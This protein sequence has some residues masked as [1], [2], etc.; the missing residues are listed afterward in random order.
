LKTDDEI[1]AAFGADDSEDE[2]YDEA[3]DAER[4]RDSTTDQG[5]SRDFNIS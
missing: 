5:L 3:D 4:R 1:L 2:K